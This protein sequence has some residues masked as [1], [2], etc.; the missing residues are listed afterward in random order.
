MLA[1]QG[2]YLGNLLYDSR[3]NQWDPWWFHELC[4]G[5]G[6]TITLLK[7]DENMHWIGGYASK[8]WTRDKGMVADEDAFLFNLTT[9]K[10]FKPKRP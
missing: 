7:L 10:T 9:S 6:P 8:S 1:Q 4:D 5:R 2:S 3:I